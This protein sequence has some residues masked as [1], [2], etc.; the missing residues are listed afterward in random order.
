MGLTSSLYSAVTGLR[1]YGTAI[2][3]SGDNIAN[4]NTAGFK[5]SRITFQDALNELLATAQ[6][7][8]QVGRGVMVSDV[9]LI[10]TQG[11]FETT[12][13]PTDLAIN[14]EGLF[15]LRDPTSMQLYYSRAGHFRLNPDGKLINPE[16]Y[17]LQG[18]AVGSNTLTD[19]IVDTAA[20]AAQATTTVKLAVNLDA[21]SEG[22]DPNTF[23]PNIEGTWNY[24]TSIVVYDSLG[25]RHQLILYF[26]KDQN[27][28]RTWNWYVAEVT[29]SGVGTYQQGGQLVFDEY[30][31]LQGGASATLSFQF[32]GAASQQIKF[33]FNPEVAKSTQYA[34]DFSTLYQYQDGYPTGFLEGITVETD[35]L[36]YGHYT[37]GQ[38]KPLYQVVLAKFVNPSG[39]TKRGGN[40]YLQSP[41]SGEPLIGTPGSGGLGTIV[42]NSLEQSNVDLAEEFTKIIIY[43]RAFQANARVITTTDDMLGEVVNLRR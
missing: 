39:L 28:E 19:V 43:Q 4:L 25:N 22:L 40:L 15:I 35:G 38:T 33:D 8:S 2:S 32:E 37:N 10:F 23:N 5:A 7:T 16:G 1:C 11:S 12:N 34:A 21:R 36:I 26:V 20:S 13:A 6:G 27:A 14:G 9:G 31:A 42:P 29:P 41:R 3:V 17:I 30:G 24:Q 18:W